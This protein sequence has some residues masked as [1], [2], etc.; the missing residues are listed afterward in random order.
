MW[1]NVIRVDG[2]IFKIVDSH[3]MQMSPTDP[4]SVCFPAVLP[5]SDSVIA[6]HFSPIAPHLFKFFLLSIFAI[7]SSRVILLLILS[8]YIKSR[9]VPTQLRHSDQYSQCAES[10]NLPPFKQQQHHQKTQAVQ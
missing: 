4:L 2:K 1:Q 8:Q 10:S 7:S 9:T 5:F 6:F 3:V